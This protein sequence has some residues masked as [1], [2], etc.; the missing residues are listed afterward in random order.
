MT[1]TEAGERATGGPLAPDPRLWL[2]EAGMA[3]A[4]KQDRI[5]QARAA[6]HARE[7]VRLLGIRW[8]GPG[9]VEVSGAVLTCAGPGMWVW[10]DG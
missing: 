8:T 6:A 7:L 1:L 3:E 5:D 9:T 10:R 4:A 2:T